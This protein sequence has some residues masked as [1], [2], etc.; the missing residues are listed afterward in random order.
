MDVSPN[1]DKITYKWWVECGLFVL[2]NLKCDRKKQKCDWRNSTDVV[3]E[4]TKNLERLN[5]IHNM[6]YKCATKGS[7]GAIALNIRLYTPEGDTLANFR[8][9][10]I[11]M[12]G[13]WSERGRNYLWGKGNINFTDA[14]RAYVRKWNKIAKRDTPYFDVAWDVLNAAYEEWKLHFFFMHSYVIWCE[15][16]KLGLPNDIDINNF[17]RFKR[18][19]EENKPKIEK[20]ILEITKYIVPT[21]KNLRLTCNELIDEIDKMPKPLGDVNSPKT[22]DSSTGKVTVEDA[23][24]TVPVKDA[25]GEVPVEDAAVEKVPVKDAAGEKVPVK[26]AAETV[27]STSSG[28]KARKTKSKSTSNKKR[29]TNKYKKHR[30]ISIRRRV[31]N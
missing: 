22:V 3:S 28:G 9:V 11:D 5:Y 8:D 10:V 27:P 25:A 17:E 18:I 15:R 12:A 20:I 2:H 6:M 31:K 16:N 14:G 1:T 13:D 29:K 7:W 4:E 23:A 21:T 19:I 26:D 24:E 30:K